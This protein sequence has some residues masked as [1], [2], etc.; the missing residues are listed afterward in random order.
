VGS[1]GGKVSGLAIQVG[2]VIIPIDEE[3]DKLSQKEKALI[4]Y[5]KLMGAVDIVRQKLEQ[6]EEKLN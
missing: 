4:I 2:S 1:N 5:A 3:E 6:K